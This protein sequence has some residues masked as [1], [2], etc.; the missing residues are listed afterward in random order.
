[1]ENSSPRRLLTVDA[2]PNVTRS[3]ARFFSSLGYAVHE[4]NESKQVLSTIQSERI[5]VVCLDIDMPGTTGLALLK[6]IR[7]TGLPVAIIMVA[8]RATLAHRIAA[9]RYGAD[10]LF[11]KTAQ[12]ETDLAKLVDFCLLRLDEWRLAIRSLSPTSDDDIR[13]SVP[14]VEYENDDEA[15]SQQWKLIRR[16]RHDDAACFVHSAAL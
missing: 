13:P 1:M 5:E 2:S 9:F 4:V 11:L 6:E 7:A 15:L 16:E 3:I 10:F 8:G 14:P 12:K